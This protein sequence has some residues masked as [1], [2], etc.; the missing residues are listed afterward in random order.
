[1]G[2]TFRRAQSLLNEGS[3]L[4]ATHEQ[5]IGRQNHVIFKSFFFA[6]HNLKNFKYI[7]L[8]MLLLISNQGKYGLV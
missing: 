5:V 1:M 7:F 6:N 8:G 3:F 2:Q 4:Q